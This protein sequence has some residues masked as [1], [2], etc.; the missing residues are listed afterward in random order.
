MYKIYIFA[1]V[2]GIYKNYI[3]VCV[4]EYVCMCMCMCVCV[5]KRI[6][7]SFSFKKS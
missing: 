4:C 6:K 5:F 7:E 3:Y 2:H 1:C